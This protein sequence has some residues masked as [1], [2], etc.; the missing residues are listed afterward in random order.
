MSDQRSDSF[1]NRL[2]DQMKSLKV[3]VNRTVR[4][5]LLL[6]VMA[7]GSAFGFA[8]STTAPASASCPSNITSTYVYVPNGISNY[9]VSFPNTFILNSS[10]LFNPASGSYQS[11]T[12]SNGFD[13]Y[14]STIY[15]YWSYS[16]F[17]NPNAAYFMVT[18]C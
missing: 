16:K 12:W 13:T 11:D 1:A 4:F 14:G 3:A 18:H 6:A 2:E 5:G 15:F 10:V 7:V 17:A 8:L 9:S